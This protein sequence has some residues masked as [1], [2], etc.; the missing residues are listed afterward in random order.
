MIIMTNGPRFRVELLDVIGSRLKEEKGMALVMAVS[1]LLILTILGALSWSVSNRQI[2][3]AG[4]LQSNYQAFFA[5]QRG[6][7]YAL[8]RDVLVSMSGSVDLATNVHKPIIDAGNSVA[9]G[10]GEIQA[11]EIVDAGPGEVPLR[12]RARYG[13][14]FGA[15]YYFISVTAE[16]GRLGNCDPAQGPVIN[17][18]EVETQVVRLFKH[19]DDSIYRTDGG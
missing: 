4:D 7:E 14:D 1:M 8:N 10:R 11:G 18:E 19:D 3:S 17:C 5:A 9:N 15:N 16:G 12:L 2:G 13:S 6:I